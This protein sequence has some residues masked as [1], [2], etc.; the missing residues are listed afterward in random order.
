M[1]KYEIVLKYEKV[2]LYDQLSWII[3]TIHI[4]IFLYLGFFSS[5]T[6]VKETCFTTLAILLILFL[7]KF[8]LL[9]TKWKTGLQPF[10][11]ILVLSWINMYQ[12]WMAAIPLVFGILSSISPKTSIAFFSKEKIFYPSFPPKTIIWSDLNNVILK[13]GLLTIDFKNNKLI[14]QPVVENETSIDEKEFNDFCRQ[15]LKAASSSI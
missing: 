6:V 1:N 4:I 10:F 15:Q 13:D 8:Y 2:N 14:Q 3:I 9:K 12:F 11:L 7:L 5:N